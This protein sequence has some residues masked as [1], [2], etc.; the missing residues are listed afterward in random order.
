M[1]VQE[2]GGEIV[3]PSSFKLDRRRELREPILGT[4]MAAFGD[5]IAGVVLTRI[6]LVDRSRSG[7]GLRSP[8]AIEPGQRVAIYP[9]DSALARVG[10]TV[11]RCQHV[12]DRYSLGIR[13]DLRPAA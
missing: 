2:A 13:A 6:E 9:G 5:E 1:T 12:G 7:F 10:G 3:E 4:A 8:V 11:M